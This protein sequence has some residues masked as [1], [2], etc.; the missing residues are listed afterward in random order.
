MGRIGL[1]LACQTV[2]PLNKHRTD[3][4]EE[5]LVS[6]SKVP[7]STKNR[8]VETWYDKLGEVYQIHDFEIFLGHCYVKVTLS[9]T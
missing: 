7:L 6:G 9:M 2:T 4:K 8:V 3:W 1:T 5:T